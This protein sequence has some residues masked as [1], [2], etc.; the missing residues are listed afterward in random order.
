M[1]AVIGHAIGG[2]GIE[3]C[4]RTL[5]SETS[6]HQELWLLRKIPAQSSRDSSYDDSGK[7]F[8]RRPHLVGTNNRA[9]C[10][11]VWSHRKLAEGTCREPT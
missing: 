7:P 3:L 9:T 11:P 2:Q 1:V 4:V 10:K 5:R 8:L 6:P